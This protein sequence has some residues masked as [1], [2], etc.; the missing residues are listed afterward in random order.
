[1]GF[2]TFKG[3]VKC[4]FLQGDVGDNADK[5]AQDDEAE[6]ALLHAEQLEE[7]IFC[8]PVPELSRELGLEHHQCVRLLKAVYGLV[9]TPRRW[10]QRVTTDLSALGGKELQTEPCLWVFRD[11]D[12]HIRALCLVYV[13]DFMIA[14]DDSQ[15]GQDIFQKVSNLYEWGT[16]ESKSFVQCGAKNHSSI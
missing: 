14:V 6:Q 4:A 7:G 10:Y 12:G 11:D 2:Q 9:N 16:W 1:M 15:F 8:E 13:D 3:D 5:E